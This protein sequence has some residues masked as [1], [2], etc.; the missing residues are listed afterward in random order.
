MDFSKVKM[1]VTDMDGT[2]LDSNHNVSDEFWNLFPKLKANNIHF[3]AASGRQYH[4]MVHKLQ[5]I[6]DDIHIIAENGGITQFRDQLLDTESL[7]FKYV[8][9]ILPVLRKVENVLIVL[10]A[11]DKAYIDTKNEEFIAFFK[12]YYTQYE[13]VEDLTKLE[14]VEVF[15]IAVRHMESSETYILPFIKELHNHKDILLKISG[16]HWLDISSIKTNKGNALEKLQKRLGV[17]IE[18][19]MAFGDY[20]NDLEMLQK[21][22]F[23]F[24]MENAHPNVKE[25]ARFST[26]T[27]DENGVEYILEKVIKAK[28][29]S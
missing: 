8:K 12:Q 14:N 28:E 6:K 18:G 10:C 20:N 19:T 17:T 16:Q 7:D 11:K 13:I 25:T 1:V 21:A 4:S 26:K 29:N 22:Y 2:L 9:E 5:A 15:K 23:S 24:A 27:N 3:V